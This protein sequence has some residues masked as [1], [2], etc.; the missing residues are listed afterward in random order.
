MD[1]KYHKAQDH[2]TKDH[3][4]KITMTF[5]YEKICHKYKRSQL[6]NLTA[7]VVIV[8]LYFGNLYMKYCWNII[9]GLGRGP[10]CPPMTGCSDNIIS[11]NPLIW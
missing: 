5:D 10:Q 11:S 2:A 8:L 1:I 6:C 3:I 4:Q 7:I 9:L